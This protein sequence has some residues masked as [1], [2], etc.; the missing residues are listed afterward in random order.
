[1]NHLLGDVSKKPSDVVGETCPSPSIPP[2]LCQS[3]SPCFCYLLAKHGAPQ[4]LLCRSCQNAYS[5]LH[6][7]RQRADQG[8][9]GLAESSLRGCPLHAAGDYLTGAL[10]TASSV[11]GDKVPTERFSA[12]LKHTNPRKHG[13]GIETAGAT[14]RSKAR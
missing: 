4:V 10:A 12:M 1:M 13:L 9:S 8:A 7:L 2:S 5:R 11:E 3:T 14:W 6:E